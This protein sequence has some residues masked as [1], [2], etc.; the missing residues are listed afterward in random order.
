M[1]VDGRKLS[2]EQLEKIRIDVVKAIQDGQTPTEAAREAGVDVRRAFEWLARYRAGGWHALKAKPVPG[3]P[4]TLSGAQMGWIYRTVTVKNP[5]QLKFPFALW[6]RAMIRELI[7]RKYGIKLSLASIGRLL[8]QLGLTCQKPLSK[9]FEQNPSLV[10]KWTKR[11]YPRIKR[12]AKKERAEIYFSDESGV[13][14]DFHAGT[15]WA[16]RGQT[17][18][19]RHTGKR[20]SLNM[21]SAVSP[22]G[23][24]RFMTSRK[25]VSAD[26]FLEFLRR[27]VRGSK[28]KIFLIVDGLAVHRAKKVTR[29]VESTQ[30][31]LRLFF[32]PPYS[33]ELNP[34]EQVWNDVKNHGVG[35]SLIQ[36]PRELKRAAESRLRFLQKNPDRVRSF[37][38]MKETRYAA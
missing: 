25:R 23:E 2:H 35:R 34:D 6:T 32:L 24:L 19:I 36:T 15:T 7:R 8:A 29:F 26:L 38:Q 27:L 12:L 1:K 30:G 3:R 10:E 37:F 16:P 28:R 21:I 17:P 22:K 9:A 4:K 18:V 20:F 33:P 11:E 31:K 13:R 5:L 14:S